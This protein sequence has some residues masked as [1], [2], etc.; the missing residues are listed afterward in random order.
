[1]AMGCRGRGTVNNELLLEMWL[2][3]ENGFD[4]PTFEELQ[5]IVYFDRSTFT[6]MRQEGYISKGSLNGRVVYELMTAAY[7]S[8]QRY[9]KTFKP[10]QHYPCPTG[11]SLSLNKTQN[12]VRR[13]AD[14]KKHKVT[15]RYQ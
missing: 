1:M 15:C 5:S 3:T 6:K 10:C 14:E 9:I 7:T 11:T 4:P 12:K 8:V 2:R 13:Y